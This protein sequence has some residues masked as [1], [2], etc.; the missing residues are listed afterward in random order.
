MSGESEEVCVAVP[1]GCSMCIG[2]GWGS[3]ILW[4]HKGKEAQATAESAEVPKEA[5]GVPTREGPRRCRYA[6]GGAPWR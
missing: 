5:A 2:V 6:T 4:R 1:L 3:H